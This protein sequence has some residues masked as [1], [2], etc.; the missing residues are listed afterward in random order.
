[1]ATIISNQAT[2]NYRY[3]TLNATA[4]S[5]I[6]TA[7]IG[8]QLTVE[9]TSLTETYRIGQDI[10]Y[11]ISISNNGS[12]ESG[13]L[14]VFDDLGGFTF[15]GNEVTPLTYLGPA[16][17]FINGVFSR[18]I[19]PTFNENGIIFELDGLGTN[20]NLQI[21]YRAR[22]NEF[23][24]GE[25]DS[26]ITNTVTVE[27]NCFCP[28]DEPASDSNAIVSEDFADVRIVKSVCPNPIICGEE[29][30]FTFEISNYGNVE[31]R[32]ITLTDTF[33]PLL[34]DITVSINGVIIPESDYDYE[35]GVLTLPNENGDEITIPPAEF[36]RNPTT[37]VVSII[38]SKITI[39]V[40]GTL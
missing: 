28:C 18:D 1:M 25:E 8:T 38:P 16:Q 37:G 9:K 4:V 17:L 3:G 19:E 33:V 35:N 39:T 7:P 22:A 2:L 20:A 13:D 15:N 29:L 36:L 12:S 5:N 14:T 26:V 10:T 11:V 34:N 32:E 27:N 6:V 40:S 24:S 23:A 21:I 31:A 30:T